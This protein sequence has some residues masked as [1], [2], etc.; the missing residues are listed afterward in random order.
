MLSC[1]KEARSGDSAAAECVAN[2]E[3]SSACLCFLS[4]P[5]VSQEREWVLVTILLK[6]EDSL[7]R[8]AGGASGS[9]LGV[10]RAHQAGAAASGRAWGPVGAE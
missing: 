4:T 5:D 10:L 6:S 2:S 1:H 7:T 8:G 3:A 9:P